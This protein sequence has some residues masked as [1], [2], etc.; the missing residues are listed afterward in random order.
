MLR[1][2][3]RE[4]KKYEIEKVAGEFY[5]KWIYSSQVGMNFLEYIIK[6]KL[7][8]KICGYCCDRSISTR[9]IKKFI[10]EFN[11]DMSQFVIPKNGYKSFN[12][13]F[14]RK[15]KNRNNQRESLTFNLWFKV[16]LTNLTWNKFYKML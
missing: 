9:K 8:S 16:P 11:I 10:N 6:R 2:Y 1:F 14:C 12:E 7:T 15:L 3:N 13:F 5:I 4:I